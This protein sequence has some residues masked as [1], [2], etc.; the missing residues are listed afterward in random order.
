MDQKQT[1][2]LNYE[3]K[4]YS[5]GG[6]VEQKVHKEIE[7]Y[8]CNI[9]GY[10]TRWKQDLNAH[11]NAVHETLKKCYSCDSCDKKYSSNKILKVHIRDAHVKIG[12]F[13]CESCNSSFTCGSNLTR[14]VKIAHFGHKYSCQKCEKSYTNNKTF[15]GTL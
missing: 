6:Q 11:I 5:S 1:N 2:I 13:E 12:R 3:A 15:K 4:Y 9:C 14:H 10:S 7:S 8:S